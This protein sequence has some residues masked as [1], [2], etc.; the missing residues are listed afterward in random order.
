ML[1]GRTAPHSY[2]P[3]Q[4]RQ[5]DTISHISQKSMMIWSIARREFSFERASE[6]EIPA[7]MKGKTNL[8]SE[9]RQTVLYLH[10][11]RNSPPENPATLFLPP[12]PQTP[13]D[14]RVSPSTFPFFPFSSRLTLVTPFSRNASNAASC[15]RLRS[16]CY[17]ICIFAFSKLG[18]PGFDS[19]LFVENLPS[20]TCDRIDS[21]G[22]REQ[23]QVVHR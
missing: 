22:S 19:E 11:P 17:K 1:T 3:T 7:K 15:S 13:P 18:I 10:L 14:S 23:V 20:F 9:H 2:R 4:T 6:R 12:K 16:C 8:R 21:N 5:D